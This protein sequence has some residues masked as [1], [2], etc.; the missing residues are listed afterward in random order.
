MT[1]TLQC[2]L[3]PRPIEMGKP[4]QECY[5]G[6][7]IAKL[8]ARKEEVE[9]LFPKDTYFEAAVQPRFHWTKP[10]SIARCWI[11]LPRCSLCSRFWVTPSFRDSSLKKMPGPHSGRGCCHCCCGR[12]SYSGPAEGN[13]N[14]R[15]AEGKWKGE[16]YD[17]DML[18]IDVKLLSFFPF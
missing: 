4:W 14:G 9:V 11:F 16:G 1:W 17:I 3:H 13:A 6:R 5:S 8:S 15:G 2:F 18:R 12:Q 10:T 7:S